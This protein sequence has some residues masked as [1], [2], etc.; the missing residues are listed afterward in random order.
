MNIPTRISISAYILCVVAAVLVL[1][2]CNKE[3]DTVYLPDPHEPQPSVAPL[4]T[5]IYDP[6]ALGDRSYND[7]LYQGVETAASR[8]GLRT[9]Q[10]SP[11]SYEEG[12]TYMATMFEAVRQSAALQDT[13]RRLYIIAAASYEQLLRENTHLFADNPYA[14]LLL[15]ETP[16]PL[17]G[18]GSTLYLPYYGA[19]YEAGALMPAVSSKAVVIGSNP[20]DRTVAGA[21]RGFCDGFGT[22]YY[23]ATK[24]INTFYLAQHAG[25]GYNLPGTTLLQMSKEAGEK[26]AELLEK[27]VIVPICGGTGFAMCYIIELTETNSYMGVDVDV[28]STHSSISC[29]K[30]IDRAVSQCID[31]WLSPEGMP[32]HQSLGLSTGYTEVVTHLT[33]EHLK[34]RFEALI[35]DDTRQLIHQD[36]IRKEAAYEKK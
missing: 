16:T 29:V 24:Q 25:Q 36:A 34:E 14:D 13:V 31:Q 27:A 28:L 4:V 33:D 17:E 8:H 12:L 21:I 26:A 1:S 5:V 18:K 35:S 7:L 9:M 22:D 3:G 15:L 30:H 10:L 23:D 32:K 11:H 19:M 20:E 6:D 2:A